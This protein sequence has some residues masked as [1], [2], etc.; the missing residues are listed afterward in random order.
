MFFD[1]GIVSFDV[2]F[3]FSQQAFV[4]AP[5]KLRRQGLLRDSRGIQSL[6]FGAGKKVGVDRQAHRLLWSFW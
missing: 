1:K 2:C 6:G 3:Y 5:F 4:A